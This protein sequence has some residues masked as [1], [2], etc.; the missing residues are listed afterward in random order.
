VGASTSIGSV[1]IVAGSIALVGC[2]TLN[3][4]DEWEV[5]G[6]PIVG[7]GMEVTVPTDVPP[8]KG[9]SCA[10]PQGTL[11]VSVGNVVSVFTGWNGLP[12]NE[13]ER[14]FQ[15]AEYYDC[16]GTKGVDAILIST[17]QYG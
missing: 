2:T 3:G 13:T 6:D 5:S 12:P 10:Y 1:A 4:N 14:Q 17:S 15:L 8:P 7:G 11:G 16:D 9:M